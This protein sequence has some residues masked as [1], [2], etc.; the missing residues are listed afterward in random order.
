M[1]LPATTTTRPIFGTFFA[2]DGS[3]LADATLTCEQAPPRVDDDASGA[4]IYKK[5]Y[6]ITTN[7]SGYASGSFIA[8]DDTDLS[9]EGW[10]YS[11]AVAAS[12]IDTDQFFIKVTES[13]PSS[14]AFFTTVMVAGSSGGTGGG[15]TFS[16]G[17]LTDVDLVTT[18]P[19]SGDGLIY[20]GTDWVPGEVATTGTGDLT[21]SVFR[22]VHDGS[23]YPAKPGW[24]TYVEFVGSPDPGSQ[25]GPGDT[26]V[27]LVSA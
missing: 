7:A 27:K 17:D 6:V 3:Y 20:D 13:I 12:G 8:S 25:A 2:T 21:G 4:L 19:V 23:I 15:G 11:V 16:L 10:T 18:P 22:S 14:G 5:P 24:A 26:W 9:P 1:A